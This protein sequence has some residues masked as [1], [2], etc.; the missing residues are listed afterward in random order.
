M[1]F[2]LNKWP[3]ILGGSALLG[4]LHCQQ[5]SDP[6]TGNRTDEKRDTV[7][8]NVVDT[9]RSARQDTLVI[10]R[11]GTILVTQDSVVRPKV[12]QI[13]AG[14]NPDLKLGDAC[15][16]ATQKDIEICNKQGQPLRCYATPG[17]WQGLTDWQTYRCKADSTGYL[18]LVPTTM[19]MGYIGIDKAS[20]RVEPSRL[21]RGSFT[22]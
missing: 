1:S 17:Q 13:I 10:I 15:D 6:E 8:T 21:L 16:V 22:A 18:A 7:F 5:A 12:T 20:T 11:S 2:P 3:R 4:L 9:A 19:N 14:V